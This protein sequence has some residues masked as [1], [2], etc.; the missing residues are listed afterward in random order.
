MVSIQVRIMTPCD[1]ELT[2]SNACLMI[3]VRKL[4]VLSQPSGLVHYNTDA[5]FSASGEH[6]KYLTIFLRY[7][8]YLHC[9]EGCSHL[10]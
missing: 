1:A 10:Y 2:C 6:I 3:N 7:C 9:S 5:S 8:N 4:D